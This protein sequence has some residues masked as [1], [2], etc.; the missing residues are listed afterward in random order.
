[1]PWPPLLR[2]G[3]RPR[4]ACLTR[5][6]PWLQRGRCVYGDA[7]KYAHDVSPSAPPRAPQG[8]KASATLFYFFKDSTPDFQDERAAAQFVRAL[9]ETTDESMAES[10]P[11]D[12]PSH[13]R[14]AHLGAFASQ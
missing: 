14:T 4:A 9:C 1:M 8:D 7:C 11:P 3:V 5:A 13:P 10:R 6:R 2:R 12:P